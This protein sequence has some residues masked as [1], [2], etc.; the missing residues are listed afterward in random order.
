MVKID[1]TDWI[2]RTC[3]KCGNPFLSYGKQNRM[4]P[5]CL[6]LGNFSAEEYGHHNGAHYIAAEPS[7]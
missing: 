3:L 6:N 7:N 1:K 4:C 2:S 5:R